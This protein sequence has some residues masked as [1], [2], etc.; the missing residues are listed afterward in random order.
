MFPVTM[1][2]KRRL[3]F[4]FVSMCSWANYC[5][6]FS[7]AADA[8]FEKRR[9][10][11]ESGNAVGDGLG[12]LSKMIQGYGLL[13]ALKLHDP[14]ESCGRPT[15]GFDYVIS[16]LH[17]WSPATKSKLEELRSKM[18]DF[19]DPAPSAAASVGSSLKL[20]RNK[21]LCHNDIELL[22][23]K[24]L[25]GGFAL[26]D[27]EAYLSNLQE[28]SNIVSEELLGGSRPFDKNGEV[29]GA[30]LVAAIGSSSQFPPRHHQRWYPGEKESESAS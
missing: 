4:E 12:R 17:S 30:A 23:N 11:F 6:R 22:L 18:R 2:E 5:W 1:S 25:V 14:A 15:L 29:E 9:K 16:R 7:L 3:A 27:G 24:K 26:E 21:T 13:E 28:F 10:L 8:E 19:I 20:A